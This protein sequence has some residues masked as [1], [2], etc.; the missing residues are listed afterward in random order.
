MSGWMNEWN[1]REWWM[2]RWNKPI[3][4]T[5]G[6]VWIL[7]L[8]WLTGQTHHASHVIWPQKHSRTLSLK[9][10][11]WLLFCYKSRAGSLFVRQAWDIY[12]LAFYRKCSLTPTLQYIMVTHLNN[13]GT[14]SMQLHRPRIWILT[15]F[16]K[17]EDPC[18]E[19]IVT[20]LH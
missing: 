18:T 5:K 4:Q 7:K 6:D 20:W 1:G 16:P 10:C 15:G 3:P 11:P 8:E 17:F 12:Y 14:F 13:P 19:R 2:R 9:H